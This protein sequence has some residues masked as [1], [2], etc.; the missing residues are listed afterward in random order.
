MEFVF[1]HTNDGVGRMAMADMS[2]LVLSSCQNM[3]GVNCNAV[4]AS[5][6][7]LFFLSFVFHSN[8]EMTWTENYSLLLILQDKVS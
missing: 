7:T 3:F 5:F 6:V 2:C 8:C 4:L 1:Y